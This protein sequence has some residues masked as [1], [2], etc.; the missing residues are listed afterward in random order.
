MLHYR[1]A[2]KH[3]VSKPF[4]FSENRVFGACHSLGLHFF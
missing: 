4:Y 2:W 1:K 3:Y